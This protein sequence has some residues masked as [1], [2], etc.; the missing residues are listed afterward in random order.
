MKLACFTNLGC[1]EKFNFKNY[2]EQ[3]KSI[4]IQRIVYLLEN[5]TSQN[6]MN[7]HENLTR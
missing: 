4:N 3:I 7:R 1:Y 5:F 2:S 6:N